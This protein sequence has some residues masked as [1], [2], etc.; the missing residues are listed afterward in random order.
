MRLIQLLVPVERR[1]A[2]TGILDERGIE[3]VQTPEAGGGERYVVQFPLQPEAVDEVLERLR[4]AGLD[5]ESYTVIARA[6]AAWPEPPAEETIHE[7][8]VSHDELRARAVGMNPGLATYYGMTVLSAVVAT[9]GLLLDSPAV[10]VGSMVIAPQVGAALTA[11]VG[12]ALSERSLIREGFRDQFGGLVV[13]VFGAALFGALVRYSGFA[14]AP[15]DVATVQQ[16]GQRISPGFLS[17][18]VG[19]AAG[20]AG[21]VGLATALP[22]SLVGVMIAAALIPAAAAIGIGLSWGFPAVALGATVLLLVNAVSINLAGLLVLWVMGFRPREWTT[23]SSAAAGLRAVW[24][25]VAVVGVLLVAFVATGVVTAWQVEAETSINEA[26]SDVLDGDAYRDL[27]LQSV[28]TQFGAVSVG[29]VDRSVRIVVR[30]PANRRYPDFA[31]EVGERAERALGTDVRV[32]VVF[33][34]GQ[35]HRTAD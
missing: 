6:E 2:I 18:A 11:S 20:A 31:A 5:E 9:A 25:A 7:D 12:T 10:V 35:A 29:N 22:V 27:E 8:R 24:P 30:R 17:A 26:V 23:A 21:A 3:Y 4:G 15:L 28:Q 16:I 1:D 32:E 33:E 13:A 19:V 14:P 34:D